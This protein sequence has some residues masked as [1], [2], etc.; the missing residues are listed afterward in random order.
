M[1]YGFTYT[2]N[3]KINQLLATEN[4]LVVA[5]D[6]GWSLGEMGEGKSKATNF[7]L[8]DK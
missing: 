4:K 7:Q 1:L 5:S 3:L 2:W 6:R 8:Y